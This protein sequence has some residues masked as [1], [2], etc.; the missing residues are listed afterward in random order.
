LLFKNLKNT[1][2]NITDNYQEI[3]QSLINWG[4]AAHAFAARF[5]I[6]EKLTFLHTDPKA[7]DVLNI[8]SAFFEQFPIQLNDFIPDFEIML[9]REAVF[10]GYLSG[11]SYEIP[12]RF[13][14]TDGQDIWFVIKG[15]FTDFSQDVASGQLESCG[16]FEC[17]ICN[18]QY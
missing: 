4:G 5:V 3:R 1:V 13:V 18:F 8:D 15:F 14:H 17:T 12:F 16:F 6:G 10:K 2:A 11:S 7:A 9:I